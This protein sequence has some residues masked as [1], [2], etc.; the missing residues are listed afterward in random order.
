MANSTRPTNTA[1]R[2]L[3]DLKSQLKDYAR[4]NRVEIEI[5]GLPEHLDLSGNNS[6]DNLGI[7]SSTLKDTTFPAADIGE[8]VISRMGKRIV[9]PGDR[10]YSEIE[11]TFKMPLDYNIYEIMVAWNKSIQNFEAEMDMDFDNFRGKSVVLKQ[12]SHMDHSV[13][14]EWELFNAWPRTIGAISFS[15][16]SENSLVEFP[17]TFAYSHYTF[18]MLND[19]TNNSPAPTTLPA[20]H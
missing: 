1:A 7:I 9:Y 5:H 13:I 18:R 16:E 14:S 19:K 8:I 4:P 11:A 20:G 15:M 2:S 10:A 12:L 6:I 17:I 3:H